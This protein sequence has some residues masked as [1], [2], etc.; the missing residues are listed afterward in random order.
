MGQR[1]AIASS[2]NKRFIERI[3]SPSGGFKNAASLI[4]VIG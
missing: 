3:E 2:V 1:D 4:K